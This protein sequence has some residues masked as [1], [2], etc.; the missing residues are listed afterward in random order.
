[1]ASTPTRLW[2][3]RRRGPTCIR[4]SG[5]S[6]PCGWSLNALS[7]SSR[8][9]PWPAS[10]GNRRAA[11]GP[12]AP[13]RRSASHAAVAGVRRPI[14]CQSRAHR[15]PGQPQPPGDL[16]DR[17]ALSQ[18]QPADL[19][20]SSTLITLRASR[21]VKSRS[22]A[23]GQSSAV[24]DTTIGVLLAGRADT[25]RGQFTSIVPRAPGPRA[26][27]RSSPAHRIGLASNRSSS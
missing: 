20:R 13:P 6:G 5:A 12:A 1:M 2:L 8:R 10:A 24:V 23:P 25:A 4:A 19:P 3:L 16:T 11:P 17:H 18:V 15:V 27:R 9:S 21:V 7:R 14:R 22:S 26:G